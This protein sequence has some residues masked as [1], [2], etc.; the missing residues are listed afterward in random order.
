MIEFYFVLQLLTVQAGDFD[1]LTDDVFSGANFCP[2][3]VFLFLTCDPL[4]SD[5]IMWSLPFCCRTG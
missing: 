5:L 2:S 1:S 4:T 3:A